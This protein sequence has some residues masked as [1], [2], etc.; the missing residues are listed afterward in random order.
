MTCVFDATQPKR[1]S[2]EVRREM[3]FNERDNISHR[4]VGV[5][6]LC[7]MGWG[8]AT[9]LSTTFPLVAVF[10]ESTEVTKKASAARLPIVES[11]GEVG[12]LAWIVICMPPSPEVFTELLT[13]DDGIGGLPPDTIVVNMATDDPDAV[14]AASQKLRAKGVHVLDELEGRG[15]AETAS[16]R[17]I[18]MAGGNP[19]L[20]D[21]VR[22][23]YELPGSEVVT[24]QA[25]MTIPA[26]GIEL[27]SRGD[28]EFEAPHG[29]LGGVAS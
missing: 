4:D 3:A 1:Q 11:I 8:I 25:I 27:C 5:I 10:D 14:T 12:K 21:S 29:I 19:H 20:V 24:P 17:L 28:L 13:D 18:V 2:R 23:L 7:A 9:W 16:G 6:G 26:H 15:P 22:W